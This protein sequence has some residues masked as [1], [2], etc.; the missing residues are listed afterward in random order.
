MKLAVSVLDMQRSVAFLLRMHATSQ[1]VKVKSS[2][3]ICRLLRES[4][5]RPAAVYSGRR[6]VDID[7]QPQT[8]TRTA[9]THRSRATLLCRRVC[10]SPP[11]THVRAFDHLP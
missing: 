1:G 10:C 3:C 8:H 2:S 6:P 9:A 7:A 5:A 4:V 11:Q